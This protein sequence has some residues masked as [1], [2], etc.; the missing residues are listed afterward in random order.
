MA[1]SSG[2]TITSEELKFLA[3]RAGLG[4]SLDEVEELKPLYEMYLQHIEPL[5]AVDLKAEE[6]GLAFHPDW[7]QG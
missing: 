4:L 7:T 5:R 2:P 1:T 3:D 6:I